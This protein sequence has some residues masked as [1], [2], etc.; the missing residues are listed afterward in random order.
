[1]EALTPLLNV[2]DVSR[3]LAF[4]TGQLGFRVERDSRA[5]DRIVWARIARG[6]I[7]LMI[8]ASEERAKRGRRS[9]AATYDDVVL[10]FTVDDAPELHRRLRAQ[11]CEPGPLEAQD[12]GLHEFTLRDPDGYELAFG[13][14]I[15]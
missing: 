1:M 4:Y 14:P 11:G 5:G 7:A 3:S 9:V 2:E 10:Y 8:N 15:P 6:A 12:Y 13:S